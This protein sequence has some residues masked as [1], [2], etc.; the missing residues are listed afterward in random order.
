[1]NCEW[2]TDNQTIYLVQLDEE[3]EDFAGV[4][5]FQLHIPTYHRPPAAEGAFLTHADQGSLQVWDKLK[6]L[7]ELWEPEASHKPTLFYVPLLALP[8][9][10][11]RPSKDK[12]DGDFR[13]LI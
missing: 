4:N 10:R 11:D 12:L 13:S 1:L 8:E 6:V 3:T 7:D 2:L 9:T 5:P